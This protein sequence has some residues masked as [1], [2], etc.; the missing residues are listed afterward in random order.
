MAA[1]SLVQNSPSTPLR[2]D[3]AHICL[4]EANGDLSPLDIPKLAHLLNLCIQ[5]DINEITN[6]AHPSNR[7][8]AAI[9]AR[10]ILRKHQFALDLE[11]NTREQQ[12]QLA[13]RR[14]ATVT[15]FQ[16]PQSN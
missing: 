4:M 8:R 16:R 3:F 7:S 1:N 14:H 5:G 15:P 13:L 2:C 11:H 10:Y 9:A 6:L 12:A